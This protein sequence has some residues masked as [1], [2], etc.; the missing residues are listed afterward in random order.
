MNDEFDYPE[1]TEFDTSQ[2]ESVKVSTRVSSESHFGIEKK[3]GGW[4]EN[5]TARILNFAGFDVKREERIIFEKETND[6]YRV[7]VLAK[8]D[9]LTLF[10]ECKDYDETKISEKI[11]FTMIGQIHDY[12]IEH[13]DDFVIGVL[14]TS[15][16]NHGQNL[17]IQ[18]KLRQENCYLWDGFVLQ[19]LQNKMIELGDSDTFQQYL[20]EKLSYLQEEKKEETF[21]G[22]DV[23]YTRMKF[24][25]IPEFMYIG[26][27]MSKK[28]L[29]DDLRQNLGSTGIE[30]IRTQY[31]KLGQEQSGRLKLVV[32]FRLVKEPTALAKHW[33]K[34]RGLFSKPK[35]TPKEL[36][37][38]DLERAC[39]SAIKDTYGV[40][41]SYKNYETYQITCVASRVTANK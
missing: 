17:G 3:S 13:P 38:I 10:V 36:M 41:R 2:T 12:R 7:D 37:G 34:Q 16:K 21:P 24:F 20:F 28:S 6:H 40:E 22:K 26:K 18:N 19:E 14:V 32:D 5:E 8:S 30:I 9:A 15:A 23:F 4:L 39:R 11:L 35:E 25:S 27:S 1:G 29:I 33:E 31:A